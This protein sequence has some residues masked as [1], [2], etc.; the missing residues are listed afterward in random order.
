[1]LKPAFLNRIN[2]RQIIIHFL[3][4]WCFAYISNILFSMLFFLRDWDLV[5]AIIHSHGDIRQID[6]SHLKGV[7]AQKIAWLAF[8]STLSKPIGLAAGFI[9]SLITS[10][11]RTWFWVNSFLVFLLACVLFHFHFS[12]WTWLLKVFLAPGRIFPTYSVGYFVVDGS[13]LLLLGLLLLFFPPIVRFI[14]KIDENGKSE[15][16]TEPI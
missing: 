14:G 11:I 10:I 9:L 4:C 6:F 1:M 8:W 2:W 15:P 12:D 5:L 7:D 13:V 3:V 16:K